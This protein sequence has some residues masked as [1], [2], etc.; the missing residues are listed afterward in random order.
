MGARGPQSARLRAAREALP[1]K[2]RRL[3]W[4]KRGLSRAE[5]VVRFLEALP[6]TKGKLSGRK[7]KLLPGQRLFVEQIYGSLDRDGRR[8]IRLAVKSEPRGNGK[9]GLVAGLCLAHL[10]GP[11]AEQR[12]EIYSCAVDRQQAGLLFAE[13]VA[14]IERVPEFAAR[15]NVI[16]FFKRI[17]VLS[18][19][20]DGSIYEALSA[21]ARRAHG[22]SPTLWCYDEL[23]QVQDAELL[24]NLRTAMGKRRES[25]GVVIS[26]QAATD[27]HALSRIIDDGLSGV[28]PSILVHLTAAPMEADPFA[29]RTLRACNPAW[30]V[31]L[32]GGTILSEAEQA[33]RIPAFEPRYRNLRLNQRVETDTDNRVV[34]LPT[35]KLGG[36]PVDRKALRGRTAYA[37]LDLSGKSDLTALV[38]A[39]PSDERE[40]SYDIVPTFWTPRDALNARPPAERDLFKQ[41]IAAGHMIEVPGPVIRYSFVAAELT[42]LAKEFDLAAIAFDAWRIDDLR[43]D[44]A[45]VDPD[46][47]VPLEPFQQGFKSMSPAIDHFAELALSGRLRHG[48]HPVLTACVSNAI[49]VHDAAGNLKVEKGKSNNRGPVRIDGA[50]ALIMALGMA[51]RFEAEPRV[52]VDDF[53]ANAVF[54]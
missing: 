30:G 53:L 16:K 17:E 47:P 32:D 11:E 2:P 31:F 34:T 26:T 1:A 18:G 38:V 14:V 33:R 23:A 37:G 13:M 19:D 46:F 5:R 36:A 48:M 9:T 35:W 27:D 7:M 21:D 25:L 52:D 8:K 4:K 45:D 15:C 42:R 10:L 49:T 22:L 40:P 12:G 43:A 51:K 28:D 39:V 24:E 54:V 44:L 29:E 20:G 6:I 3:P 41:W 50:V